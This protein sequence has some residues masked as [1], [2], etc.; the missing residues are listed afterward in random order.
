MKSDKDEISTKSSNDK[1]N[2]CVN[3]LASDGVGSTRS[4]ESDVLAVSDS[5]KGE[6]KSTTR[7]REKIA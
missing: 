6:K 4:S 2:N 1:S 7:W 3:K 5:G